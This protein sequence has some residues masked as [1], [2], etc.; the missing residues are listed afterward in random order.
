MSY[1]RMRQYSITLP[2]RRITDSKSVKSLILGCLVLLVITGC[3]QADTPVTD[4]EDNQTG[5]SP[6]DDFDLVIPYTARIKLDQVAEIELIMTDEAILSLPHTVHIDRGG[7]IF[8][9]EY[10]PPIYVF[11]GDGVFTGSVGVRGVGPGELIRIE[12][13]NID[14]IGNLHVFD[15]STSRISLFSSD[16]SFIRSYSIAADRSSTAVLNSQGHFVMLREAWYN[17][18]S[19]ALAIYNQNGEMISS[20]GEIPI[21]AK[22]Q[23]NL[24]PGGGIAVDAEDNVYYSYISDH[25]IWKTDSKGDLVSIFDSIPPYYIAPD[26]GLLDQLDKRDSPPNPRVATERLRHFYSISRIAGIHA[27]GERDLIFQEIMT[28]EYKGGERSIRVDLEVWHNSGFK[29]GSVV[30]S[31][32]NVSFIDESHIYYVHLRGG[33]E[34]PSILLYTYDIMRELTSLQE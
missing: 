33:E 22:V 25:R 12:T 17:G 23:S 16:Y 31:P 19:P 18:L 13:F 34:N 10:D 3:N 30:S 24:S 21:S 28:P 15:A 26:E 2:F 20:S 8:W 6:K 4:Q 27:V 14:D 11:N 1:L 32:G 7:N 29:I 9:A 5:T